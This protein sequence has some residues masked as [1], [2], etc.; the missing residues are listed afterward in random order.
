MIEYL[1]PEGHPD[2]NEDAFETSVE[3]VLSEVRGVDEALVRKYD[4]EL[5]EAGV[6]VDTP[7]DVANPDIDMGDWISEL[8]ERG[9]E[10][11]VK[12]IRERLRL[13]GLNNANSINTYE[14]SRLDADSAIQLDERNAE[15]LFY[16]TSLRAAQLLGRNHPV[17]W[18]MLRKQIYTIP[19]DETL[20]KSADFRKSVDL[21]LFQLQEWVNA[22]HYLIELGLD[23]HDLARLTGTGRNSE[24]RPEVKQNVNR[25]SYLLQSEPI[26]KDFINALPKWTENK[27]KIS[28]HKA[29]KMALVVMR[30]RRERLQKAKRIAKSKNELDFVNSEAYRLSLNR[31]DIKMNIAKLI[32]ESST[33]KSPEEFV[34]EH[35]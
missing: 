26:L 34:A 16:Y 11:Y 1:G 25:L 35:S 6:E 24:N 15:S 2:A 31:L 3:D 14:I 12:V 21:D 8:Q 22:Q 29:T 7:F 17:T 32:I 20:R 19:H 5:I 27:G 4:K 10:A 23:P 13:V 33:Y 9:S 28:V 30:L 18:D